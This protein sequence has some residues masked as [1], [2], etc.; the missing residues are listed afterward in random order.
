[1]FKSMGQ[2]RSGP[3]IHVVPVQTQNSDSDFME[4]MMKMMMM[5]KMMKPYRMIDAMLKGMEDKHENNMYNMFK[6]MGQHRSG[7]QIHV[8]PVQTQNSDSDFMEKM[9]KMM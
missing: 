6:S 5:K 2:H 1:M 4:K 8:V 9:M 7:P 3:Q